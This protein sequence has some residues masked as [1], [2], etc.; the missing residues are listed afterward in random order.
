MASSVVFP[1]HWTS[2][3]QSPSAASAPSAAEQPRLGVDFVQA[4]APE[5]SIPLVF[6]SSAAAEGPDADVV[7]IR[8][9]LSTFGIAG[10]VWDCA[11]ALV[12]FGQRQPSLLAHKRVLE[13]GAGTGAVG[14]ALA[15]SVDGGLASLV[16]TDLEAVVPLTADN[17]RSTALCHARLRDLLARN[18]LTTLSFCWGD[19]LPQCVVDATADVVLCSDCLYEP[20]QYANLLASL[21]A[22]TNWQADDGT[23]PVIVLIA[24]KQRMPVRER[25]FFES[26]VAFFDVAVARVDSAASR[27][28]VFVCQLTRSSA[29]PT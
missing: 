29:L 7:T 11:R 3:F 2:I 5:V 8:Q 13:L 19:A 28:G 12:A 10:V 24:Y 16:L 27:D 23:R 4:S 21:L 18:A 17:V 25:A 26:A 22:L 1:L 15:L 14:L 6:S 9:N 20:S